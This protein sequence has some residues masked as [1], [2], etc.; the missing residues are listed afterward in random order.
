LKVDR[1]VGESFDENDPATDVLPRED[2]QDLNLAM[3]QFQVRHT[4]RSVL[5]PSSFPPTLKM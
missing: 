1:I 5:L 2:W 4:G 3:I